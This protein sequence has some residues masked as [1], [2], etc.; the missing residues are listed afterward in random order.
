MSLEIFT[1]HTMIRLSSVAGAVLDLTELCFLAKRELKTCL[2][3]NSYAKT[4]G[5]HEI[6]KLSYFIVRGRSLR[7]CI[8]HM[9]SKVCGSLSPCKDMTS[10]SVSAVSN[11]L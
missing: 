1:L 5:S 3:D 6:L 7:K 8:V 10:C 9:L 4:N 11:A 2:S